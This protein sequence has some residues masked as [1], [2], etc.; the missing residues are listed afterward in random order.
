MQLP[1]A[2]V[3]SLALTLVFCV[4]TTGRA[5]FYRVCQESKPGA[6]D[7]NSNPV[8]FHD[9]VLSMGMYANDFYNYRD[10]AYHGTEFKLLSNR[11]HM[12]VL[13]TPDGEYLTIILDRKKDGSGGSCKVIVEAREMQ[14]SEHSPESPDGSAAP[15]SGHGF[16]T[17]PGYIELGDDPGEAYLDNKDGQIKCVGNFGWI[18]DKTDGMVVGPLPKDRTILVT[19][20]EM[21][22]LSSWAYYNSAH[23]GRPLK[24]ANDV[25]VLIEQVPDEQVDPKD[26]TRSIRHR[27]VSVT[28]LLQSDRP[29]QGL[30][31]LMNL[32]P[33][34]AKE[35]AVKNQLK[36]LISNAARKHGP[37]SELARQL[38]RNKAYGEHWR[39]LGKLAGLD[40]KTIDALLI[41]QETPQEMLIRAELLERKGELLEAYALYKQVVGRL[42]EDELNHCKNRIKI[43]ESNKEMMAEH[44]RLQVEKKEAAKLLHK[45]RVLTQAKQ[46]DKARRCYEQLIGQYPDLPEAKTAAE[47]LKVLPAD[48]EAQAAVP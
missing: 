21:N 24:L 28:K 16:N 2:S 30:A 22:S 13:E 19:L 44:R 35:P 11:V 38:Q 9:C 46:Y 23:Q 31:L 32:K 14:S 5:T 34:Q 6:E 37:H 47:L 20:Q 15:A 41:K 10:A 25:R 18:P 42:E 40:K 1:A 39:Q 33:E 3:V 7:F 45:G 8:G 26:L 27:L 17:G 4:P 43:L 12:F 48:E 36:V 29:K